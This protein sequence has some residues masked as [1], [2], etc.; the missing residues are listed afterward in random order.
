MNDIISFSLKKLHLII[1]V[2]AAFLSAVI[3]VAAMI[4]QFNKLKDDSYQHNQRLIILESQTDSHLKLL[5][6][7]KFN[8]KTFFESQGLKYVEINGSYFPK[9]KKE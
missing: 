1:L 7:L 6:E 8:L 3:T 4:N 5:F 2:T 9:N